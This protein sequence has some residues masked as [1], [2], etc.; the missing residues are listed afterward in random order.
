MMIKVKCFLDKNAEDIFYKLDDKPV[1][2]LEEFKQKENVNAIVITPVFDYK[3]IIDELEKNNI[4]GNFI[5]LEDIIC[6]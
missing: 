5:S 1:L 2:G 6:R 3:E 4:K